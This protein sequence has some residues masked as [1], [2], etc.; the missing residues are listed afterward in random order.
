MPYIKI[1]DREKFNA[2]LAQIGHRLKNKGE[3]NYC[4]SILMNLYINIH[5]ENYQ[6]LSDAKGALIDAA[7][8]FTR[9]RINLYE[10]EKIKENGDIYS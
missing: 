1:K 3:L 10:D 4:V 8:E 5:G 7:D 2:S 9:R 6:N